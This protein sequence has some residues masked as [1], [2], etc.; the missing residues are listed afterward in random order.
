MNNM[1]EPDVP[2]RCPAPASWPS[3][4]SVDETVPVRPVFNHS[5]DSM[6]VDVPPARADK[7]K[8]FWREQIWPT[9]V[10]IAILLTFRSIIVD[11]NV[12]P[13]GSMNPTII[14]GDRILVNKLA[15]DL[16]VPFTTIE[17]FKWSDP[18]RGDIIVFDSPQNGIRL[19]KRVIGVPGDTVQ[20]I[21]NHLL[22]NGQPAAYGTLDSDTAHQIRNADTLSW[23]PEYATETVE[24]V[25]HA[26]MTLEKRPSDKRTFG[27]ET[28]PA[29]QYFVMGDD[30]DNSAD[31]RYIGFVPRGN[32][33]GR[34]SRVIVSLGDYFLPRSDRWFRK[35]P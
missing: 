25:T 28:V 32:I 11:W 34:S 13:S 1:S 18:K 35:L 22:I 33:A 4:S 23:T 15:Y 24:G 7:I 30:R 5:H 14:E 26:M 2:I 16:K 21:D 3:S 10:L 6:T 31:S 8:K 9:A 29:G 27:P 17:L 20:L 19:V 12:V